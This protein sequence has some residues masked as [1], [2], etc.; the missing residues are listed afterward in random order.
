MAVDMEITNRAAEL[1]RKA[2]E[3]VALQQPPPD[4]N[5]VYIF[6]RLLMIVSAWLCLMLF[7]GCG[8][9][10]GNIQNSYRSN[11]PVPL[12]TG[13]V[14]YSIVGDPSHNYPWFATNEDL[15]KYGYVEEE[16]FVEGKAQPFLNYSTTSARESSENLPYKTRVVVRR[17][18]AEQSFSGNVLLE[19]NNVTTGTDIDFIWL[20]SCDYIMRSGH[21][22]VGVTA[23][24]VGVEALKSWSLERYK[25]LDVSVSGPFTTD[26]LSFGIYSQVAQALRKSENANLLGGFKVKTILAAG[27]SQSGR[28]LAYY[29]NY[30]HQLHQV[31]DGFAIIAHTNP[32]LSNS[33]VKTMR[34]LTETD[35]RMGKESY[36]IFEK[37]VDSE[38]F[39]R[40]EVAGTSHLGWYDQSKYTPLLMRERNS[41]LPVFTAYT[42]FSRIPFHHTLNASYEHMFTWINTGNAPPVAPRIEWASETVVARDGYGNALGGIRLP[43]H[44]VPTAVNTGKAN[45]PLPRG[46][47][48]SFFAQLVGTYAPFDSAVI[49]VLYPSHDSYA[50]AV[51]KAADDLLQQGFILN[52]EAQFTIDNAVNSDIGK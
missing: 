43:D 34:I 9:S 40:W 46:P 12:V 29:H 45:A 2:E 36:N 4:D 1:R 20:E 16:F 15:D 7:N 41:G 27:P 39:R 48:N 14:P 13:P 42:A 26:A 21:A 33:T 38:T 25:S 52:E 24:K 3:K 50:G 44:Q 31:V 32:L 47:A 23:Q 5:D 8:S 22:Y 51:K 37:E 10:H 11:V 30:V 49:G 19:W 6:F 18:R 35:V 28:Y 17:P